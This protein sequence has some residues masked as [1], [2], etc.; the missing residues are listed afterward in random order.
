MSTLRIMG[1]HGRQK[2]AVSVLTVL[3]MPVLLAFVGLVIDV[4]YL[5]A[6]K[7]KIQNISDSLA[8]ACAHQFQRGMSCSYTPGAANTAALD[9]PTLYGVPWSAVTVSNPATN[10]V[11]VQISQSTPT[12][13]MKILGFASVS[14]G[15]SA[16]A[17]FRPTCLYTL[18][19]TGANALTTGTPANLQMPSCGLFIHSSSA[20]AFNVLSGA[21]LNTMYIDIVGGRT[22]TGTVTP[23][24]MVQVTGIGDPLANLPAPPA[25]GPCNFVNYEYR[26]NQ[27]LTLN[28]GVYCG[29][30]TIGL[31]PTV[32]FNP[33]LYYLV[34]GGLNSGPGYSTFVGSG[35]TFY[36]TFSSTY[37]YGPILIGQNGPLFQL[38]APTTG[39]YK[40][41]LFFQDRNATGASSVFGGGSA[42][43]MRLSGA[44]YFKTTG[45][46]FNG[47]S[48]TTGA[49]YTYIVANNMIFNGSTRINF[50]AGAAWAPL[51]GPVR[52]IQ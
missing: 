28:P 22:A 27:A 48:S 8:L 52:L 34:G 49:S 40:G 39:P 19:L 12:Y 29:G 46:S 7:R 23:E 32:T 44:L 20:T 2:G 24:P 1:D 38:S 25:P 11:R 10:Q 37:P 31:K 47:G 45:V 14:V 35:V 9:V 41:I 17:D 3:L 26:G 30:I 13:F 50:E 15:A 42:A 5:Y 33:G 6:V 51:S 21:T 16:M 43:Q 4:G 36:N 18:G